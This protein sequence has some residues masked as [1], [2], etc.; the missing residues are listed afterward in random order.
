MNANSLA[1]LF[2]PSIFTIKTSS[3]A[4]LKPKKKK[5]MEII[6]S[7][8]DS[9]TNILSKIIQLGLKGFSNEPRSTK[10]LLIL[11]ENIIKTN[12]SNNSRKSVNKLNKQLLKNALNGSAD[13]HNSLG[14]KENFG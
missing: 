5:E 2:L 13:A 6:M 1:V 12:Q 3:N 9:H 11:Y 10:E 7:K 8:L 4:P 14:N